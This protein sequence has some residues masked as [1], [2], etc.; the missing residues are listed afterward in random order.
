MSI[1]FTGSMPVTGW[2]NKHSGLLGDS[3]DLVLAVVATYISF[4]CKPRKHAF[5]CGGYGDE[6]RRLILEALMMSSVRATS[7]LVKPL[8]TAYER[9]K[10]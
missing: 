5:V 3:A 1:I 10:K 6:F 8:I 2:I 4:V 9:R 7:L